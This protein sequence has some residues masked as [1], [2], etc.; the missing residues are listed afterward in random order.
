MYVK[1]N[2]RTY[3]ITDVVPRQGTMYSMISGT[4]T[5]GL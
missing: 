1:I 5:D 4:Y 2:Y 3:R